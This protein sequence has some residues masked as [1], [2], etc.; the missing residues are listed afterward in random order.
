MA[1]SDIEAGR[2]LDRDPEEV[3]IH[4][5]KS[6]FSG[7]AVVGLADF[8]ADRAAAPE[9]DANPQ[10][11]EHDKWL[12]SYFAGALQRAGVIYPRQ[13]LEVNAPDGQQEQIAA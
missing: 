8:Y 2:Y 7:V 6:A 13:G 9:A 4:M 3:T 5:G 10:D 1:V 11:V 12:A